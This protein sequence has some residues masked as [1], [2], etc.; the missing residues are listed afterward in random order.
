M[1]HCLICTNCKK[2]HKPS[3]FLLRCDDCNSVLKVKYKDFPKDKKSM[4]DSLLGSTSISLGDGDTP[5]IPLSNI[6][7]L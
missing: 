1:K 7:L 6:S 4:M 5:T 2:K 3:I